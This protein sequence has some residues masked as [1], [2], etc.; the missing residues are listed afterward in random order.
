ML[1][2]TMTLEELQKEIDKDSYFLFK[3]IIKDNKTIIQLSRRFIPYYPHKISRQ[4]TS[5]ITNIQYTITIYTPNSYRRANPEYTIYTL[6]SHDY[7]STIIQLVPIDDRMSY[8]VFTSHFFKRYK[9]RMKMPSEMSTTDL[10]EHYRIANTHSAKIEGL[11]IDNKEK[12]YHGDDIE[13]YGAIIAEGAIICERDLQSPDMIIHNTF[14]SR[15]MFFRTQDK[16]SKF[17]YIVVLF[18]DFVKN[19]PRQKQKLEEQFSIMLQDA[20]RNDEDAEKLF[21]KVKSFIDKY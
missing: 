5:P 11:I 8:L 17:A 18:E 6:Y 21:P 1:L 20:E 12:Y 15:D 3:Q 9:E 7:G 10:F 2:P 19:Y 16:K 13:Y 4:V 14:I